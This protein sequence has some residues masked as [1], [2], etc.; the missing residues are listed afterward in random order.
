MSFSGSRIEI[1]RAFEAE[2]RA[3]SVAGSRRFS[4]PFFAASVRS[5]SSVA[6]FLLHH[7]ASWAADSKAGIARFCFMCGCSNTA[8][9]KRGS[10]RTPSRPEPCPR[11][12]SRRQSA[13]GHL[14]GAEN[15]I[16]LLPGRGLIFQIERL[17]QNHLLE[18]IRRH[19]VAFQVPDV[20]CVPIEL[21]AAH[22]F[23]QY[24]LCIYDV[25]PRSCAG[26]R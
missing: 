23:L 12:A 6:R 22:H 8:A 5:L 11:A 1:T 19:T 21:D 24:T 20:L 14:G 16:A 3:F 7:P 18:F 17:A 2:S 9:G 15:L 13:P 10:P 26:G 4:S 25:N